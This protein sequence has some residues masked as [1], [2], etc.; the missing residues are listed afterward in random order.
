[1]KNQVLIL[2]IVKNYKKLFF[3]LEEI[4]D[5]YSIP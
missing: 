3:E 5:S 2:E 4:Q 1:M